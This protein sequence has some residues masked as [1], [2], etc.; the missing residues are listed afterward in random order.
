MPTNTVEEVNLAKLIDQ[1]HE[2]WPVTNN[3]LTNTYVLRELA[4]DGQIKYYAS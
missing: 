3:W 4:I 1:D 2:T